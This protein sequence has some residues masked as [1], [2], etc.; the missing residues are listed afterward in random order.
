MQ[1]KKVA[2]AV[3][4]QKAKV[5]SI[6][7]RDADIKMIY[8]TVP[9]LL[10]VEGTPT[11]LQPK[12][13]V[14]RMLRK[15]VPRR[16]LEAVLDAKGAVVID[17]AT[18]KPRTRE[19]EVPTDFHRVQVY[20][21]LG[22]I[23]MSLTLP[24]STLIS[25]DLNTVALRDRPRMAESTGGAKVVAPRRRAVPKRTRPVVE[26][27]AA[28]GKRVFAVLIGNKK[29]LHDAANFDKIADVAASEKPKDAAKRVR[30]E[31]VGFAGASRYGIV[32]AGQGVE[33]GVSSHGGEGA[34]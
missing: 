32:P 23:W 14:L 3:N 9:V 34:Q 33:G 21:E 12:P 16:V 24:G 30:K 28:D 8:A 19:V 20:D 6:P 31:L 10:G 5:H 17:K 22:K 18:G 2:V 1:P 13:R 11:A 27:P 7:L 25:D 29:S 4:A 15:A 26:K